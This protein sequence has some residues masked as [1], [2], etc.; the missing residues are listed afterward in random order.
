MSWLDEME[1]MMPTKSH[2]L[3]V[4]KDKVQ[5]Q[6]FIQN[7]LKTGRVQWHP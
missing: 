1:D 5:E 2:L 3:Q 6:Q 4:V 7:L